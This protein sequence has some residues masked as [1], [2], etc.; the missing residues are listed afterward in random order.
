MLVRISLHKIEELYTVLVQLTKH[1]VTLKELQSCWQFFFPNRRFDLRM[2][3]DAMIPLSKPFHHLRVTREMKE[4]MLVWLFFLQEFNGVSYIPEDR[5]FSSDSLQLFTDSAG[6]ADLG[7]ACFLDGKWCFFQ[8]PEKWR[9]CEVLR[10]MTFLEMIPVVLSMFVWG[11]VLA[12]KKIILHIDNEA[13]VY[14]LNHQTSKSKRLMQ[15]VRPFVLMTMKFNINFKAVHIASK[16][17]YI[18][19]AISRRKW[20]RFYQLVPGADIKPVPNPK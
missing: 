16:N 14:V 10:D 9:G 19:D 1:K 17:N 5:W 2:F 6:S 15:L 4:D 18:A 11:T 12:N 3:Y 7:A 13:L 20:S 8:W